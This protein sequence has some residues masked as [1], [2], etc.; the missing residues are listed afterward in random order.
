M[1]AMHAP[2]Y[3]GNRFRVLATAVQYAL[4]RRLLCW[5][6]VWWAMN[7]LSCVTHDLS[8]PLLPRQGDSQ[9]C[10]WGVCTFDALC[11]TDK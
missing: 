1:H 11:C 7:V 5:A 2:G 3:F 4:T 10:F 9:E 8:P 6:H